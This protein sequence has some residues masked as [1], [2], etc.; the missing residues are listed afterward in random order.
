MKSVKLN[1]SQKVHDKTKID[2]ENET[3]QTKINTLC[4]C[5]ESIYS[6]NSIKLKVAPKSFYKN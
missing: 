3:L 6:R 1:H 5:I 2:P 4:Y